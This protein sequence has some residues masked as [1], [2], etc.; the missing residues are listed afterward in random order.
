MKSFFAALQSL[1]L[2]F[3]ATTG[4]RIV[5][6]GVQGI[7][8]I[9]DA[10]NKLRIRLGFADSIELSSGDASENLLGDL[11]GSVI[12]SGS[13]RRLQVVLESPQFSG[14]E[15]SVLQLISEAFGG[16]T[17]F[18]TDTVMSYFANFH[19]FRDSG[20]AAETQV[21]IQGKALAM[22]YEQ[23][24]VD[25]PSS[26]FPLLPLGMIVAYGGTTAPSAEWK[27][28]DGAA[29]SRTTFA[30]LFTAIGTAFGAGD[31]STTF[32]VPDLRQRFPLGKAA[33]GTGSTLGGTG[34]SID[35]THSTP[36]HSHSLD[37]N[38]GYAK[39]FISSV[40]KNIRM[41]RKT[42]ASWTDTH[43][44]DGT[45]FVA[46]TVAQTL[47]ADLGGDTSSDGSG[48]SGSTNP[49]FQSVNYLIRALP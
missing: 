48:T 27:L 42:V 24:D 7:I 15:R 41:L 8:A 12:G 32:N 11:Q 34:G 9:Y 37:G 40:S 19:N 5:L 30:A 17:D 4:R 28:C 47:G 3:G 44:L 18:N 22:R 16:G 38:T 23:G 31:G 33:S 49:P 35:H 21:L 13:T 6:D 14:Q 2:P 45:G 46:E 36:A 39:M 43:G 1:T 26:I 25:V 20:V 10:A 29:I